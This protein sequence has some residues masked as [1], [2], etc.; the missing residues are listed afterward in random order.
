MNK[1][2]PDWFR[3]WVTNDLQHII[4]DIIGIKVDIGW[5]K[6]IGI[7]IFVALI[8]LALTILVS[9]FVA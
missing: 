2:T 4:E 7:G 5:L 9:L 8:I 3:E 6:K 1:N